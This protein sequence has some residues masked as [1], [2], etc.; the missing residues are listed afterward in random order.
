[1]DAPVLYRNKRR[2]LYLQG[3]VMDGRCIERMNEFSVYYIK[4]W[5]RFISKTYMLTCVY[6]KKNEVQ[7]QFWQI[8]SLISTPYWTFVWFPL[9]KIAVY[10][11][12]S[13]QFGSLLFRPLVT[14]CVLPL[15]CSFVRSLFRSLFRSSLRQPESTRQVDEERTCQRLPNILLGECVGK[16]VTGDSHIFT[17]LFFFLFFS[18][19][20]VKFVFFVEYSLSH[21]L[22]RLVLDS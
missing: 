21:L 11:K 13:I 5:M 12:K 15:V 4:E 20:F 1:M 18:F 9:R 7:V 14:A 16:M 17:T 6:E 19:V 22:S 3:E 8:A 2:G 10:I